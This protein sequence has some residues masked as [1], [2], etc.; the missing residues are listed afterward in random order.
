MI[1]SGAVFAGLY[2]F[3]GVS[4]PDTPQTATLPVPCSGPAPEPCAGSAPN[5]AFNTANGTLLGQRVV[6]GKTL[7]MAAFTPQPEGIDTTNA[8]IAV[9]AMHTQRLRSGE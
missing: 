6:N 9:D 8:L 4:S 3:T 2:T 5:V 1:A 7:E